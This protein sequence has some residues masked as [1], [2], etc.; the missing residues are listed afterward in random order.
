MSL[1]F[2]W[3]SVA[4]AADICHR[5]P[6]PHT[7]SGT[8]SP[9]GGAGCGMKTQARGADPWRV[10]GGDSRASAESRLALPR[11]GPRSLRETPKLC[12][13]SRGISPD[14]AS[15]VASGA[16]GGSSTSPRVSPLPDLRDSE[17][18][19]E[20]EATRDGRWR[21]AARPLPAASQGPSGPHGRSSSRP[22][23][24]DGGVSGREGNENRPEGRPPQRLVTSGA[25]SPAA[26]SPAGCTSSQRRH[27]TGAAGGGDG[28]SPRRPFL[29]SACHGHAE[30]RPHL[31]ASTLPWTRGHAPPVPHS[32]LARALGR[33]LPRMLKSLTRSSAG[34]A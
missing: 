19:K 20:N 4:D 26:A 25:P 13:L 11:A 15:C 34:F 29:R 18:D 31:P 1:S 24:P 9:A 14:P 6:L 23:A 2:P 10:R 8:R 16:P 32:G 28:G 21:K 7:L 27:V 3:G 33:P 17:C 30:P 12:G 5:T 22:S